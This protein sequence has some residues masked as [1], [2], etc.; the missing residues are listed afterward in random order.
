MIR[1]KGKEEASGDRYFYKKL[2]GTLK[3]R[4]ILWGELLPI[5]EGG[6]ELAKEAWAVEVRREENTEKGHDFRE[7][8]ENPGKIQSLKQESRTE[9]RE[10][11][12]FT[13]GIKFTRR[14]GGPGGRFWR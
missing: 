13:S 6:R 9:N 2:V 3:N 11:G 5:G 7:S 4:K 12:N 10:E 8:V 14:D 1:N